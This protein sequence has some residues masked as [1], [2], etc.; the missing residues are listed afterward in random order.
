MRTSSTVSRLSNRLPERYLHTG[1]PT[2]KRV[3]NKIDPS[4]KGTSLRFV[5]S[6]LSYLKRINFATNCPKR[7]IAIYY[8][9]MWY[10]L[11]HQTDNNTA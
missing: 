6:S 4:E 3:I 10:R 9:I 8:K 1:R 2:L 5:K 11:K 7:K